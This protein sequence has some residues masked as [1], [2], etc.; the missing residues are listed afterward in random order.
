MY[1]D[2]V[3]R[4]FRR[5]AASRDSLV[6]VL[7]KRGRRDD[8]DN[9][10]DDDDDGIDKSKWINAFARMLELQR[11]IDPILHKQQTKNA[12]VTNSSQNP[13]A[14]IADPRCVLDEVRKAMDFIKET[15]T[16]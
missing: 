5:C 13:G 7:L 6:L 1:L 11:L 14:R 2:R 3:S 8:V 9:D 10:D 4:C 12:P 15:P 16:V